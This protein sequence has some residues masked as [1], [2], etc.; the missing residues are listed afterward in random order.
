[1]TF[2]NE[3]KSYANEADFTER[4][5]D[6]LLRRMGYSMVVNYHGSQEFGKDLVFAEVNRFGHVVY[7]GLQAKFESSIPQSKAPELV[8]DAQEA[9]SVPF[10]HPQTHT[11]EQVHSFYVVNAGSISENARE[12]FY[13]QLI[14]P[15]GG[16]VFMIDG[17]ALLALDRSVAYGRT[18]AIGELL[19]G[20]R[21][22]C[23]FN[24]W[25]LGE[26][27]RGLVDY[28]VKTTPVP[29]FP[30][31]TAAM[32]NYLVCPYVPSQIET[33][34]VF[35]VCSDCEQI[36]VWLSLLGATKNKEEVAHAIRVTISKN[37]PKLQ[38]IFH[39]CSGILAELGTVAGL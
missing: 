28:D 7:H 33:T 6:P 19:T 29:N 9:F 8:R 39:A 25:R 22:E 38:G 14:A 11:E 17:P 31:R 34:L 2:P 15:H 21:L 35:D 18:E 3:F 1:M 27:D 16:R 10:K 20:L 26:I 30:T 5:L 24:L 32:S 36:N 12:L 37:T 4:F 23:Q 13:K